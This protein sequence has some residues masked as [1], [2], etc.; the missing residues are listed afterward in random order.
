[1]VASSHE[2]LFRRQA[3]NALSARPFGRPIAVMP[4]PWRWLTFLLVAFA[5]LVVLFLST[6]EYSRKESVRGWLVARDGVARI[7][8]PAAAVID[9]IATS[10]GDIVQ[11]G[12]PVI[13]LSQ[14]RFLRDG[15]SSVD[16]VIIE[17]DK[18]L[19]AIDRRI[20][21]LQTET[22]IAKESID[23]EL[24]GLG[25]Q[26]KVLVGQIAAQG[27]RLD[28]ASRRLTLLSAALTR[29]AITDRELSRERDEEVTLRQAQSRLQRELLALDRER[30][31]LLTRARSLPVEAARSISN[32]NSERS[33][34]Q[35]QITG[36]LSA[37]HVVLKSPISGKLASVEV[38]E[39]GTIL[40]NQLLATV[41]PLDLKMVAEVYV[42]S[43]AV[44]FIRPGQ[45]VRLTYDAF[46]RQKFGTF[47]GYV[48][49]VS[50]FVLMP[51][52]VPQ[53]FFP[54]EATFKVKIELSSDSV[55]I[56]SADAPLR[57]GMLLA[58]EIV[59][60]QRTLAQW[61]LEPLRLRRDNEA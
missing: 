60:E 13:Y 56:D 57:P 37:R 17:L 1:M 49:S 44:G 19:A 4:R 22:T 21:L 32:L 10:S 12:D 11:A 30:E 26:R 59:L 46:P 5:T 55:V 29:G 51:S 53:T 61:L 39:G 24:R 7:T 38:H 16:E 28:D 34:L 48:E 58:A 35:Q 25:R 50:D 8:H 14:E 18:Q 47:A 52:E 2:S 6:A 23:T 33:R 40:P 3:I 15:R 41:L 45:S 27:R 9:S 42:P 31:Q 43:S 36:H 20:E 54:R